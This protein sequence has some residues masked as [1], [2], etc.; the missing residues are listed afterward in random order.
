MQGEG[1]PVCL[2]GGPPVY[3][4]GGASSPYGGQE[5]EGS[6]RIGVEEYGRS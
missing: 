3:L 5:G 4:G 2:G 1:P 6:K